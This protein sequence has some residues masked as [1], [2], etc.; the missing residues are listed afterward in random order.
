[1]AE[2]EEEYRAQIGSRLRAGKDAPPPTEWFHWADQLHALADRIQGL[3]H[4]QQVEEQMITPAVAQLV[5]MLDQSLAGPFAEAWGAWRN[6]YLPA[7]DDLLEIFRLRAA[8]QSQAQSN[9]VAAA[10]NPHLP[11]ARRSESLSRKALWV[12]ASTPGVTTVLVGMR[13]LDY[14]A[15]AL[16]ILKWPPLGDARKVYDS[17]REIRLP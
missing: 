14:V 1:V 9:R 16:E 15:D 4:W 6:R 3:D 12:L 8:R 17:I 13:H 5:T 7:L 11:L 10:V 2:L